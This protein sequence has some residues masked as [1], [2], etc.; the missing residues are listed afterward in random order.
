VLVA[1]AMLTNTGG[2]KDASAACHCNVGEGKPAVRLHEN[3]TAWP[4][5]TVCELG[6]KAAN[7]GNCCTTIDVTAVDMTEPTMFVACTQ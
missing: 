4:A 3:V 2:E 5:F 6:V 7:V 1:P